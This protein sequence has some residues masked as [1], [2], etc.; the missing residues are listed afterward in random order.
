MAEGTCPAPAP[1][2]PPSGARALDRI[3]FALRASHFLARVPP[4]LIAP[5]ASIARLRELE[6]GDHL[7]REGDRATGFHVI[8]HG[9]VTGRRTLAS[10]AE[11]I[12]AI[13]GARDNVGDT[14]ALERSC[15]PADA[16]VTS[17]SATVV[18][19]DADEVRA[20]A[21]RSPE[22]ARAVQESLCRQSGALRSK[23]EILG[24]GSV[25]ARLA[26]LFVHLA[27]RF[28]D[29]DD[30]GQ[31]IVP[32]ALSRAALA[33]LVSARTET[34]IRTLRPWEDDGLLITRDGGFVLA[35]PPA[36]RAIADEG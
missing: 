6:A 25:P 2:G 4:S 32:V 27:A 9:L 18:W 34:V 10:G 5:L 13:F 36:L 12:V 8:G 33:S 16:V 14:A 17:D 24:A 21:A 3:G 31:V 7:W 35:D 11:L 30:D 29:Q 1:S 15:Y 22:L 28:G 19:L 20:R 23:V 26:N